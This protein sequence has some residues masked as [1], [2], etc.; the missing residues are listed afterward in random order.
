MQE[1]KKRAQ[2]QKYWLPAQST[3]AS[4]KAGPGDPVNLLKPNPRVL[5][6]PGSWK[7]RWVPKRG[8]CLAPCSREGESSNPSATTR[9]LATGPHITIIRSGDPGQDLEVLHP[10]LN[11]G[12]CQGSRI[13]GQRYPG[14]DVRRS[15]WPQ[16]LAWDRGEVGSLQP[17]PPEELPGLRVGPGGSAAGPTFSLLR[18]PAAHCQTRPQTQALRP[19][20][21]SR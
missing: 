20:P 16:S 10:Q 14:V 15:Q 13:G 19:T 11:P 9:D 4:G 7:L 3:P 5:G 1:K 6:F 21:L 18:P 17:C 12:S 8:G 2:A